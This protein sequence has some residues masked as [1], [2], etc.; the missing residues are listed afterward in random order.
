MSVKD[1]IEKNYPEYYGWFDYPADRT[2]AFKSIDGAWGIFGNFAHTP[3]VVGGVTF[4]CAEK[5]FQVMKFS[6]PG[7]RRIIYS[8]KGRKIKMTAK[9]QARVCGIRPDWGEIIVDVLKFCLMQKYEQCEAFRLE[10]ERSRGLDIVEIQPNPKRPADTYNAKLSDDGLTWSGPN[11]M[12][13]L[14]MELR[15][16]GSL[17]WN[18]PEDTLRFDDLS[19]PEAKE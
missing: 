12:G 6:D 2:A 7:A 16:T 9:N 14:L 18:L 10:L 11:L 17:R 15:D 3:I 1:Y 5:L 8:R 19:E 4:D 13:R